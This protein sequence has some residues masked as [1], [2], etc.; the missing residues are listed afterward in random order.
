MK[1]M[2]IALIS[3]VVFMLAVYSGAAYAQQ[4]PLSGAKTVAVAKGEVVNT[5]CP[6]MGGEV[7]K[8]TP[9]KV[10][11]KGK[12]IGLC[13]AGCITAFNKDPEKYIG[14]LDTKEE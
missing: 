14:N 8:D 4:C 1:I 6:V 2:K 5:I 3:V 12:T 9:F 10:E 13:C 11:Y 7:G